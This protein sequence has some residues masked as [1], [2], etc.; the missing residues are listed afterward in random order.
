[1]VLLSAV[2]SASSCPLLTA[3]VA[4]APA[5]TLVICFSV[6]ARPTEIVFARSAKES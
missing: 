3:S 5:A 6:P 1:M 4:S 2:T